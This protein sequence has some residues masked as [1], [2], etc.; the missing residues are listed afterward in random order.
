MPDY[1]ATEHYAV[2]TER[3]KNGF[4]ITLTKKPLEAPRVMTPEEYGMPDGLYADHFAAA[5]AFGIMREGELI[6]APRRVEQP[7]SRDGAVGKRGFSRLRHRE[8][9]FGFCKVGGAAAG[10]QG[11]CARNAV[12]QYARS[13]VLSARRVYAYGIGYLL[14]F[15]PRRRTRRSA[16]RT[17]HALLDVRR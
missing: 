13:S 10:A 5:E 12:V 16:A 15:Q 7:S 1:T 11:D 6:A 17:R 9:T 14:L 3:T 2:A 4:N 8:K